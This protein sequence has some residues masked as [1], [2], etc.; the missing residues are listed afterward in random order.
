MVQGSE[1]LIR[2]ERTKLGKYF[3]TDEIYIIFANIIQTFT[4]FTTWHGIVYNL[5]KYFIPFKEFLI[6]VSINVVIFDKS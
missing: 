4:A 5:V 3:N 2:E 1:K 6:K